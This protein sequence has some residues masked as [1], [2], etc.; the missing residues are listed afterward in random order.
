MPVVKML[1]VDLAAAGYNDVQKV[2]GL[3]LLD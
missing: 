3:A 2:E 1:E